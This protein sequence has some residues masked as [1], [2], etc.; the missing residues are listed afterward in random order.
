MRLQ[1]EKK[2]ERYPMSK[3]NSLT[4]QIEVIV[5]KWHEVGTL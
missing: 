4:N 2:T 3:K 5:L 1:Q